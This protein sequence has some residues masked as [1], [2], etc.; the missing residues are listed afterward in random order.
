MLELILCGKQE[1]QNSVFQLLV[2]D[3]YPKGNGMLWHIPEDFKW[4]Q[5]KT[6]NKILLVG[7]TTAKHMPIDKIHGT[8]G[9]SVRILHSK[10]DSD[11]ILQ[12]IKDGTDTNDYIICGGKTIYDYFMKHAEIDNAYITMLFSSFKHDTPKEPL[13]VDVSTL[14]KNSISETRPLIDKG[15]FITFSK[16]R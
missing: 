14:Y 13:Y 15:I 6:A 16:R 7:E 12:G 4:F 2:G 8:K 9:R 11:A 3:K 1:S 10:E 5:E